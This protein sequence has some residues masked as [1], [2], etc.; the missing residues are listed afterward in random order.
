[1]TDQPAGEPT[2]PSLPAARTW[3]GRRTM[4]ALVVAMVAGVLAAAATVAAGGWIYAPAIG[5]DATALVFCSLVW[6]VIWPMSAEETAQRAT[7]EDPSRANTDLLVLSASVASLGAVIVVLVHAHSAHGATQAMLA[8]LGV[9][10]VAVSW[11]TVHTVFLLRYALLYYARPEGGIDFKMAERPS[12]RDFAY[13]ALTLGMTYQVSDTD[14]RS[15]QMRAT[16]LRHALLSYLF[17]AVI[18]AVAINLIAG[19]GSSG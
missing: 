7:E 14:L 18:L 17:G 12:Y 5:W 15:T 11:F 3:R 19:L 10:S 13:V 6:M 1:M 16:A 9:L 4:S 8:G 2:G